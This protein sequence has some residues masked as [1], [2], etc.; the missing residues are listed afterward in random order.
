MSAG[1]A[2]V[3]NAEVMTPDHAF[4]GWVRAR[5]GRV[6]A[7]GTGA[8]PRPCDGERVIDA[9]GLV[10]APGFLDIHIH[11]AAGRDMMEGRE[12]VDAVAA[13][14]VSRG[15]TGFLPTT[16]TAPWA[17]TLRA[18]DAFADACAHPP[19]G[20]R[21]L[22]LHLEG[23]FLNP[24]RRGMQAAEYMRAPKAADAA[25][26]LSTGR[27]WVRTVTLAPELPGGLALVSMLGA[28]GVVV[29]MA[30][31]DASYAEAVDAVAAGVRRVTHCFHAM[32]PLH[33]R[34]P[35]LVGAALDL[36][37]L[38][39]EGIADGVHA[40]PAALRLLWRVKGWRRMALVSDAMAGAGAPDGAYR[41][42]GQDVV[43]RGG[44][45]HL[46]DGTLAGSVVTVDAAVRVMIAAGVP[47]R[48]AVGMATLA[49]AEA[50]GLSGT[51]RLVPGGAADL[52]ALDAGWKVAWTMVGGRMAWMA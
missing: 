40:H 25:A 42:G 29:A 44:E 37:A 49:P 26:L 33:H 5:G 24:A 32:T 2:L 23:P 1:D 12:A 11:G 9:G 47:P 7:L 36:D 20:A 13:F 14:L 34:Q 10:V 51:G 21:P 28:C 39:V 31:S 30:H 43:V 17:E 35:G 19:A 6:A 50:A 22:G 27:G 52:V 48:E 15:C 45:A 16:V 41:F 4:R 8:A 3:A 46:T 18:V 38:C